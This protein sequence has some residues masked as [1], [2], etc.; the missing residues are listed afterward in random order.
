M[1]RV[2]IHLGLFLFMVVGE[3]ALIILPLCGLSGPTWLR[4]VCQI[5]LTISLDIILYV[6]SVLN[7]VQTLNWHTELQ[8]IMI[9]TALLCVILPFFVSAIL[10]EGYSLIFTNKDTKKYRQN[11]KIKNTNENKGFVRVIDYSLMMVF[12]VIALIVTVTVPFSNVGSPIMVGIAGVAILISTFVLQLIC[13]K[14][15]KKQIWKMYRSVKNR[16]AWK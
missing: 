12:A 11:E 3:I 16:K 7:I 14:I 2:F 9:I 4:V 15:I 10:V 5:W 1:K 13:Y 8:V 6:L